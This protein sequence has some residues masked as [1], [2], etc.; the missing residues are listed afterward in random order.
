MNNTERVMKLQLGFDT[1]NAV[2]RYL[3]FR[4]T[5]AIAKEAGRGVARIDQADMIRLGLN[6]GDIVTITGKRQS[7]ARI[8]STELDSAEGSIQIDG[9]MREN[10]ETGIGEQVCVSKAAHQPA[11]SVKITPSFNTNPL[12]QADNQGQGFSALLR[13]LMPK[14]KQNVEDIRKYRRLADGLPALEGDRIRVNLFGRPLD[15]KILESV[16]DGVVVFDS[17]TEIT[18]VGGGDLSSNNAAITYEDIG[19]LSKEIARVREMVE[20]PLRFPQLFEQLGVDPPR[21]LLLYGPPGCGKTL[22]ARAVAR[23][24]GVYFAHVNGPEIIQ[25]HYGASEQLLRKIF[26]DAQEYPAAIIF[27]DEIDALAPNRETV[28]GDVEKR[29]VAQLLALMDGL[30]SRGRII[31][32]AAT[33]LPNNIDPALRRP[34]RFDREIGINP[35]DKAGRLEIL[36]IHTRGMPLA[37]DVDME[38]LAGIT[39]GFLGADLAALCREAAMICTREVLPKIDFLRSELQ[40][41]ELAD[42]KVKMKHFNMALNEIE[43]STM[44]QVST[45]VADVKWKDV[46]G[47]DEVKRILR[48]AVEWP[49]KYCHRFEYVKTTPPKGILLTGV[50]GTGKTLIAKAVATESEVNFISV[51]GPELLSK[52]VGESERGIREIF[53]KA[54]QSAP[55]I[56]FFDEIDAIVPARGTGDGGSHVGDRMVGQFLLEMDSIEALNAVVILAATNRPDL[57]DK[58]L[59]RPGRF[60][61][62][63]ELPTPDYATRLEILQI[64]SRGRPLSRNVSLASIAKVTEGMTGADL[65]AL[66]RRSAMLAVK[67]SIDQHPEKQFPLFHI[68]KYHFEAALAEMGKEGRD[69]C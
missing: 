27:F 35:P 5:E 58:A 33:N 13:K 65:E 61:Y 51:K 3:T 40:D 19:G 67:E 29:V 8:M 11:L 45:E 34:G 56:L 69:S 60:D 55:S 57:I 37:E 59:L 24:S 32:I 25:Q 42:I 10:V 66:C 23:E 22:I 68:E 14:R 4:V 28:L 54:R 2:E 36:H 41:Q 49:L 46:G 48:E 6:N 26:E 17:S 21:G 39:H 20:V 52:W 16:P 38:R 9:I 43:L 12:L 31:V 50:P 63:V 64:F 44:R 62:V 18:I 1:V 15:F 7:V 30:K 53:K 47:L